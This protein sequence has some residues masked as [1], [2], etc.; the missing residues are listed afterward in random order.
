MRIVH[1]QYRDD[2]YD[3]LYPFADNAVLTGSRGYGFTNLTFIDA[4]LH[5][6]GR[7][8]PQR[9]TSVVVASLQATL[10][11]GDDSGDSCSC[12]VDLTNPSGVLPLKDAVGRPAGL[13]LADVDQLT[14]LQNWELGTHTFASAGFVASATIPD[15][16]I[17]AKGVT[18]GATTVTGDVWLVGE[19]GVLL[20]E[21]DGTIRI[22]IVGDPLFRRAQCGET[23][24]FTAPNYLKTINGIAPNARGMF[25]L[26]ASQT[27]TDFPALRV[28]PGE[29]GDLVIEFASGK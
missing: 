21:E 25:Y 12:I 11:I 19:D 5:P 27:L 14:L 1:P 7:T 3:T 24:S 28:H 2:N 13:L 20:T 8:L 23:A 18:D 26:F 4:V 29:S 17:Y 6:P 22:D 16:Q 9:L 15:P 10:V